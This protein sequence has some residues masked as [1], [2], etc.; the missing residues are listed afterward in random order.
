MDVTL[1]MTAFPGLTV[2]QNTLPDLQHRYPGPLSPA[3]LSISYFS[4]IP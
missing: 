2:L 1:D 4:S 3:P